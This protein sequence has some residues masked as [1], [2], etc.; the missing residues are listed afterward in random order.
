MHYFAKSTGWFYD[1][2]INGQDIP[3]DAVEIS[4]EQ[5]M[6][7]RTVNTRERDARIAVATTRIAP[8]QDAVG[9]F[10]DEPATQAEQDALRTWK[11]YRLAV[12]RVDLDDSAVAWPQSPE[13]A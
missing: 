8:L 7:V 12:A 13:P 2:A 3:S 11:A 1:T 10:G 4:R 5:L 6:Q 9:G